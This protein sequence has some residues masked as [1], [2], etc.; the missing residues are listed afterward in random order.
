MGG[1]GEN[2][3]EVKVGD[4]TAAGIC[5]KRSGANQVDGPTEIALRRVYTGFLYHDFRRRPR[6]SMAGPRFSMATVE[7]FHTIEKHGLNIFDGIV[8]FAR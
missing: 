5:G 8:I 4:N 1:G 3:F 7:I 2:V 6:F